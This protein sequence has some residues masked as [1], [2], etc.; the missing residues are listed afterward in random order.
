MVPGAHQGQ[1][2]RGNAPAL[3]ARRRANP[4]LL[5]E[6]FVVHPAHLAKV[7]IGVAIATKPPPPAATNAPNAPGSRGVPAPPNARGVAAD[8]LLRVERDDA[9]ASAALEAELGRA[10]QL[11]PRDRALAT[12]LVYGTLRVRPWLEAQLGR[13]AKRGV[14]SIDPRVRAHLL[15]AAY[16]IF[17]LT[18]VP[19]FAAVSAAVDGVRR[20]TGKEV[21]GFANAVLRKLA[22]EAAAA[23]A[24]GATLPI[25]HAIVA[26]AAPWLTKA[27]ETALGADG[28]RAF[29]ASGSETP[30]TCLRVEREGER[31]AWLARIA[32]AVPTATLTAGAVSP[33]AIVAR[34]LGRITELPGFA[35]GAW[36]IQEE[37][38][39]LI[40]LALGAKPGDHVLDACAGRGNKTSLLARAVGPSGAVDAADLHA[41]KLTRLASELS[42]LSLAPRRTYAVDWTVGAGDVDASYDRILVDAPCTGVG[43]LRRRPE[44]ATRRTTGDLTDLTSTQLAIAHRVSERLRPGGRLVYAVCSVLRAEAEDVCARLVELAPSLTPAPFEPEVARKLAGEA[45]SLRLLPHVHGTDGYFLASFV[46]A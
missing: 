14:A 24:A 11:E 29:L 40:A 20:T 39:Q 19:A 34:G 30:P 8:V 9:Y 37:G 44:L 5:A 15:V 22:G 10:V 23:A 13:H 3:R 25:E 46:K 43:T 2:R 41:S 12:E 33:Q 27:L 4:A 7:S 16:Q 36:T 35:E 42:R 32:E 28:A 21:G 1:R 17:F 26:S 18:R 38:S 45:T 31:D 6:R